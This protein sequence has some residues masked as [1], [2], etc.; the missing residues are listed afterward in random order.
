MARSYKRSISRGNDVMEIRPIL[1]SLRKHRIPAFL[2]VLEITLACA[3]MLNAVFLIAQ[4]VD[5]VS[6]A[7]AIDEQGLTVVTT[8]GAN[9]ADNADTLTRALTA[10]RG[11]R[12]VQA[13]TAM[14]SL[15]LS[16]NAWEG[17]MSASAARKHWHNASDYF[18]TTGGAQA[19]GLRLLHGRFFTAG[20]YAT[21]GISKSYAS[22]SPVV[23]VTRAFAEEMWPGQEAVGK[24]VFGASSAYSVVGVVANVLAPSLTVN[25]GAHWYS[26]V[27][28]PVT[29]GDAVG[30]FVLRSA[31]ADRERIQQRAI[32][33][34]TKLEPQA[35]I[36]GYTF[37]WLRNH[38]FANMTSLIWIL[39]LV[40]VIML[41]VTAFGI[42][43]L[44][45][46]WVTQRRAQIGIRRTL[47]ARRRDIAR[48]FQTENFLLV[49]AGIVCGMVLAW[50]V[51][52]FLMSR[53]ELGHMPLY[54]L[55][56]G[57][58]ALWVLGQ[59]AVLGPALRASHVP[60]V[61]ATR[62]A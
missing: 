37:S 49:T 36:K 9:P 35:V 14:N 20:E 54:Y 12:G 43:G 41:G 53:Y 13:V 19:L 17:G 18:M 44:T 8:N 61:M 25:G 62:S 46:F 50:G 47:G 2:I 15:P 51:N 4:R 30:E 31:P 34:L 27:F 57:A 6:L 59:L 1:S 5:S 23:I 16:N 38:Y 60:P 28:F 48:Y 11:I 39:A 32:E 55:I 58:V 7:N 52:L 24:Q 33:V 56:A 3:V 40:C 26:S 45:S 42:V 29:P 22:T 10:L 21:S